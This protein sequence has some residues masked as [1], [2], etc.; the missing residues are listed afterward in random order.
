MYLKRKSDGHLVEVLSLNDLF[1]PL[2]EEVVGRLHYGEEPQ[3]PEK[4]SKDDLLFPSGEPLPRCWTD[5]HYRDADL[6]RIM[7][8]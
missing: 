8:R 6:D 4:F 1:N 2:H 7:R 5:V 3:D